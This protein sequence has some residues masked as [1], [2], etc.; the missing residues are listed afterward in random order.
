MTV[1]ST[2]ELLRI[3]EAAG[4]CNGPAFVDLEIDTGMGRLGFLANPI[5]EILTVVRQSPMIQINGVFAPFADAENDR[6]FTLEQKNQPP[7]ALRIISKC[8]Q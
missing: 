4:K 2:R 3:Q 1:S 8:S 6:A 5:E 7:R